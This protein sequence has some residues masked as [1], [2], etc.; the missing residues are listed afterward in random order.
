MD[1]LPRASHCSKDLTHHEVL[2][3]FTLCS[4][5]WGHRH[6]T[7]EERNGT[8]SPHS[9][10][11]AQR[12]PSC[13]DSGRSALPY[14]PFL[15]RPRPP[16]TSFSIS[17]PH[18]SPQKSLV[19]TSLYQTGLSSR[20]DSKSFCPREVKF[21]GSKSNRLCGRRPPRGVRDVPCITEH[22]GPRRGHGTC[23]PPTAETE[24]G[25][26]PVFLFLLLEPE[27]RAQE[28]EFA[29]FFCLI[30]RLKRGVSPESPYFKKTQEAKPL[31]RGRDQQV[32][33]G[34]QTK[35]A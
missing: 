12:L 30:W 7:A 22:P 17:L 27:L 28:D 29:N 13:F 34:A 1:H 3:T 11:L 26:W 21:Q 4:R 23:P 19:W 16:R 2:L 32:L 31:N 15:Q 18:T 9:P 8:S 24:L 10:S 6:P 5:H 20:T 14:T 35:K 25:R 33:L